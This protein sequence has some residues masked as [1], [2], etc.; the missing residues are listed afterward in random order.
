MLCRV[1]VFSGIDILPGLGGAGAVSG[2][3]CVCSG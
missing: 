3:E 1:C 2:V